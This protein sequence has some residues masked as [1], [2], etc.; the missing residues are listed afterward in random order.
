[1]Q[2]SASH[3]GVH[4]TIVCTSCFL[5]RLHLVQQC[6]TADGRTPPN[7][8]TA[9]YGNVVSAYCPLAHACVSYLN[10]DQATYSGAECH[11]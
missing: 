3:Q 2:L 4:F 11:V 6:R 5:S 7:C 1:M 8:A 10:H 9:P